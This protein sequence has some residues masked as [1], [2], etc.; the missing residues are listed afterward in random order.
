MCIFDFEKDSF[1]YKEKM[2]NAIDVYPLPV[3]V[4]MTASRLPGII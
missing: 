3:D 1:T 4:I 2:R